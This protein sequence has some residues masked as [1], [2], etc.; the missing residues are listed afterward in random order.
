MSLRH[1]PPRVWRMARWLGSWIAA[2]GAVLFV[3]YLVGGTSANSNGNLE[4][5]LW[6]KDEG[7]FMTEVWG[8]PHGQAILGILL[9]V[10]GSVASKISPFIS[11]RREG[12]PLMSTRAGRDIRRPIRALQAK[13]AYPQRRIGRRMTV[14]GALSA[15]T[16]A[17]MI[18]LFLSVRNTLEADGGVL[19]SG[20]WVGLGGALLALALAVPMLVAGILFWAGAPTE[21]EIEAEALA[22]TPPPPTP[23]PTLP[24]PPGALA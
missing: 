10:F 8:A 22:R 13:R 18:P 14:F 24:A 6:G 5:L 15:A 19:Q 20:A 4:V 9:L 7:A 16:A 12:I 21:P 3:A 17:A 23:G 11:R 2:A 1:A